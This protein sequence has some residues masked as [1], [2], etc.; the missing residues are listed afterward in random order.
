MPGPSTHWL[1][2][3]LEP[4]HSAPFL[5]QLAVESP[6]ETGAP[7]PGSHWLTNVVDPVRSAPCLQRLAGEALTET[8]EPGL[9]SSWLTDIVEPVQLPRD[10][11]RST[12]TSAPT[13]VKGNQCGAVMASGTCNSPIVI[14]GLNSGADD[15][16]EFRDV[17]ITM[18]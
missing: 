5:Q 15:G 8:G 12:L 11:V 7:G 6:T 3:V 1:T 14:Q 2:D 13:F 16:S 10:S 9:S 4:L 17:C 18:V